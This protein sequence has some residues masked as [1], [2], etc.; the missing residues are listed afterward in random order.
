LATFSIPSVQRLIRRAQYDFETLLSNGEAFLR[1]SFE[2]AS[3]YVIGGIA[4]G[5]HKHIAWGARQ[6]L[7]RTADPENV[8]RIAEFWLGEGQ[9]PATQAEFAIQVVA[10]GATSVE[11][12]TVW[13]RSDGT[14]Y[15]AVADTT[16]AA[17]G[18]AELTVRALVAG[19][20]GNVHQ[21]ATLTL[22]S[23]IDNL[24]P[25]AIVATEAELEDDEVGSGSDVET[26]P[27]VVTRIEERVRSPVITGGGPGDY[28]KW[29]KAADTGVTRAW[30]L[31]RWAGHST[32]GVVFVRDKDTDIRPDEDELAVVQEYLDIKTPPG[33]TSFA[34]APALQPLNPV[35]QLKPDTAAARAAITAALKD[36]VLREA[37]ATGGIIRIKEMDESI[38][39]ALNSVVATSPVTEDHVLVSPTANV[40]TAVGVLATLGTPSYSTLEDE[41]E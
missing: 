18:E 12:G 10:T 33:T 25:E 9:R 23:P 30:E 26:I 29:A 34:L 14:E 11:V 19:K 24:E 4:A 40:V 21:S 35:I 3:A 15:E 32:V 28:V 7:P 36:F 5:L 2:Y 16:I 1:E 39:G 6:F 20:A 17:A 37:T 8:L 38:S 31:N 27:D 22:A 13:T 41:E